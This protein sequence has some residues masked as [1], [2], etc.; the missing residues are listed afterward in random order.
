MAVTSRIAVGL[1][2]TGK[3][4][5]LIPNPSGGKR[6]VRETVYGTV[7]REREKGQ[8]E[9]RFD[10]DGRRKT[11]RNTTLKVVNCETGIPLEDLNQKLD[12]TVVTTESASETSTVTESIMTGVP[13]GMVQTLFVVLF[14]FFEN[15]H[16]YIL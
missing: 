11:V 3:H 6:R 16:I 14:V 10:F 2:V 12:T 8:W 1:R 9:A 7:I 5:P 13:H 15:S 4:G